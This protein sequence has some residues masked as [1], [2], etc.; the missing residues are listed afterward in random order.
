MA[1]LHKSRFGH[2]LDCRVNLCNNFPMCSCRGFLGQIRQGSLHRQRCLLVCLWYN[3]HHNRC[4]HFHSSCARSD[5]VASTTAWKNRVDICICTW[6]LV[7]PFSFHLCPS[8]WLTKVFSVCATSIVRVIAV[9]SSTKNKKDT[10]CKLLSGRFPT[11]LQNPS[12]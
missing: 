2:N 9:A 3:Q 12:D 7:S 6:C 1:L 11:L 8:K 10:T 5:E 4:H